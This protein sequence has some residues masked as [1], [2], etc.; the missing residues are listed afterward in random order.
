MIFFCNLDKYILSN[1][2]EV[3]TVTNVQKGSDSGAFQCMSENSEGVLFKEA[4]L[5][6]IGMVY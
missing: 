3:L 4:L 2:N 1:N 5:K 6:V